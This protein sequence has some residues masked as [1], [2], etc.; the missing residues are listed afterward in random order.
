M[1]YANKTIHMDW[2]SKGGRGALGDG[3]DAI[4]C[5]VS[6]YFSTHCQTQ[7]E[8]DTSNSAETW[9]HKN[10]PSGSGD[11]LR[12]NCDTCEANWGAVLRVVVLV[13]VQWCR[14]FFCRG[15]NSPP[16]FGCIN[17][18]G[19]GSLVEVEESQNNISATW[20]SQIWL[21]LIQ[22]PFSGCAL[23]VIGHFE[24][25]PTFG[26]VTQSPRHETWIWVDQPRSAFSI[27]LHL[28]FNQSLVKRTVTCRIRLELESISPIWGRRKNTVHQMIVKVKTHN[29]SLMWA[30][31]PSPIRSP[32][33]TLTPC[34]PR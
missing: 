4:K 18:C 34:N 23:L 11:S 27:P 14:H 33:R 8:T 15:I 13:T 32:C 17:I 6:F 30:A 31:S 7:N 2:S 22:F 5:S 25:L 10:W 26:Q 19:W 20:N 3:R 21:G 24:V 12:T 9:I 1:V 16:Y 28:I 29:S